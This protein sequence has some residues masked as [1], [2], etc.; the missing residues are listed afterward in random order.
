MVANAG[1]GRRPSRAGQRCW[2][3]VSDMVGMVGRERRRRGQLY[4]RMDE[5]MEGDRG[6]R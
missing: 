5:W 6:N 4:A 2:F 3:Q 1:L